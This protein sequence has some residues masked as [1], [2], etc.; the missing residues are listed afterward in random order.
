MEYSSNGFPH[1][2]GIDPISDDFTVAVFGEVLS[3]SRRTIKQLLLDQRKIA[4]VGN[5]YASESLWQ[6]RIDP[7]RRSDSLSNDEAIILNE[8][9]VAVLEEA[10]E[11]MGTTIG[12][13]VSDYR[14]SGGNNGR[15]QEMLCVYG[16]EG[17]P[18]FRC[19]KEI[20]RIV[21]Q[22]RA[23]YLCSYCQE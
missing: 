1:Q 10:I 12:S 4:G 23:T 15:F 8:A 6:A 9:I 20:E 14:D 21:Q 7:R 22:G 19:K 5:I 17:K 2:L 18:C 16:R 11:K 3:S 13:S